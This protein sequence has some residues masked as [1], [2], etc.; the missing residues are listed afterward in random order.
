MPRVAA[1]LALGAAGGIVFHA[2]HLPL[3]WMLGSMLAV[4][5]A[6]LAGFHARVPLRLRSGM[7]MVLGVL[8]G[9]AFHPELLGV[10]G[11]WLPA[12]GLQIV[13]LAAATLACVAFFRRFG[14]LDPVT[15]FFAAT[16]GGISIMALLAESNGGDAKIVSV[17]H[18]TRIMTVVM[19]VPFLFT[20]LAGRAVPAL[21]AGT[22]TLLDILPGDALWLVLA[23][24][25]GLPLGRLLRFPTPALTGPLAVS[26]ALHLAG[27]SEARPPVELVAISQVVIGA[28][29]G[30]M[31]AGVTLASLWRPII[32]AILSSLGMIGSAWVL[33]AAV[34]APLGLD[35]HAVMLSL[36]PGGLAEMSLVA[37][38]IGT[39]TAFVS[40]MHVIR[41]ALVI[42]AVP[43]VWRLARRPTGPPDG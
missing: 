20:G 32:L 34:A 10:I 41:I 30:T 28:S 29:L 7:I 40:A 15:G 8:L 17:I 43:F 18:A 24:L 42:G 27:L 11:G 26:A 3:A 25:S 5:A 9:S 31:F 38:S 13:F 35:P 21:P 23:A 36:A 37:L 2:L 19:V 1:T 33:A 14:G 39:D 12:I 22:T 16:P 6:A 4:M